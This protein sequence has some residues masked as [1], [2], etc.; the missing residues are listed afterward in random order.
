[1]REVDN[2]G[3]IENQRQTKRHQRVERANDEAIEEVEKEK[4]G[5]LS[6]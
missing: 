5:H 1:M 3:K 6:A 4:L 2:A